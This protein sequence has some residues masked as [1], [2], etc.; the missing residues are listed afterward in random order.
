MASS[1]WLTP[2]Q[3]LT[4]SGFGYSYFKGAIYISSITRSGTT[5]TV[6]AKFG[7]YNDGGPSSYYVYPINAKVRDVT[8]FYQVVAGNVWI[9]TNQWVE[10]GLFTF[11]LTV[12]V[13][14]TTANITIDWLYNN[15]Y[16][17]NTIVYTLSFDSGIPTP[18]LTGIGVTTTTATVGWFVDDGV[19]S[20]N[21]TGYIYGGTTAS[22]TTELFTTTLKN[23]TFVDTGLTPNTQ[24]YYRGR[25]KDSGGN[26]GP[27]TPLDLR[28]TTLAETGKLYGSVGG[29]ENVYSGTIR[30]GSEDY[31]ASFDAN[32]FNNNPATLALPYP[33][34]YLRSKFDAADGANLVAH[35]T[36]GSTE[37]L[38]EYD[39]T[40]EQLAAFGV[41]VKMDRP[42]DVMRY[43]DLTS[44]TQ[45]VYRSKKI[46]K[47]YGSVGGQTKEIVKLYGSVNGQTKLVY[48][49]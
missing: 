38:A 24:Y 44:S 37:L 28:L 36:N 41:A 25:I 21:G 22:P 14:T 33:A 8:N 27:Y 40:G 4:S 43:I 18:D 29:Q 34:D 16:N 46:Q 10:T 12:P 45:T 20:L 13:A 1:G 39:T 26:W 49:N 19:G 30:S 3:T 35:L 42:L 17:G 47:L 11:T 15:G 6:T 2:Y 9:G 23:D 31:F 48:Q 7:V 5:V 32:T